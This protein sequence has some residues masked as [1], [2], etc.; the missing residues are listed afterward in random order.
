MA[1]SI[2]QPLINKI[3]EQEVKTE[4]RSLNVVRESICCINCGSKDHKVVH[5]FDAEYFDHDRFETFSWDGGFPLDLTIVKCD[6]CGLVYQN[7][8]FSEESLGHLYPNHP[9]PNKLDYSRLM[10]N[11]K[12]GFFLNL[13]REYSSP[14][15]LPKRTA[16]DIGTRYGVLPEL[17]SHRGFDA[18]GLEMNLKCVKLANEAGFQ[19]VHHGT[20]V[21]LD[22]IMAQEKKDRLNL[23]SMIDVVEHLLWPQRDF[24]K[25][26]E[27]QKRGD[28]MII[29]TMDV[30]SLG[31][32]VFGKHWY[33]LHAQ[34]TFYFSEDTIAMLLDQFGY[35]VKYV[36]RIP[37]Y[38]NLR[39]LPSEMLKMRQHK[40]L[41]TG[42]E[43]YFEDGKRWFAEKRPSLF[44]YMNV[45]AEKR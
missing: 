21:D 11:H 45:I 32:K 22:K 33:F 15:K 19:G 3:Q 26:S 27:Y 31:H 12:F 44:D 16:L 1:S 40:Q 10:R 43:K 38:K 34:H 2:H 9:L 23:V 6:D 7:P 37:K 5:H 8:R 41:L 29:S 39:I 14:S 18:F 24:E 36:H 35:D 25:I 4:G 42:K 28:K 17:L 13:V 30:D 20:V